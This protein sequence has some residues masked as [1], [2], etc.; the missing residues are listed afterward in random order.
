MSTWLR[1]K[2]LRNEILKVRIIM[3]VTWLL[4]ILLSSRHKIANFLK[5]MYLSLSK[6]TKVIISNNLDWNN[7]N[8]FFTSFPLSLWNSKSPYPKWKQRRTAIHTGDVCRTKSPLGNNNHHLQLLC[9]ITAAPPTKPSFSIFS[10]P[11]SNDAVNDSIKNATWS[12]ELKWG[13]W[14]HQRKSSRESNT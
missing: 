4:F 8:T 3:H 10:S 1:S 7:H 2:V 12:L 13:Q 6:W 5:I 14:T 11:H 9:I